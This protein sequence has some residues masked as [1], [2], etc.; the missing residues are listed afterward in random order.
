MRILYKK[1]SSGTCIRG[2]NGG[3]HEGPVLETYRRALYEGSILEIYMGGLHE[4]P[5]LETC[6]RGLYQRQD[7]V[8]YLVL[9]SHG[10]F[11]LQLQSKPHYVNRIPHSLSSRFHR[12][13]WN[14]LQRGVKYITNNAKSI[15]KCLIKILLRNFPELTNRVFP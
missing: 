5:V 6:V 2:L 12:H 1:H 14:A 4:V 9:D 15:L 10:E 3:L 8:L 7:N 11:W 13:G